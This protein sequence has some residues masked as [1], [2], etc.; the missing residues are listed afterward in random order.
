MCVKESQKYVQVLHSWPEDKRDMP[1]MNVDDVP[2]SC[3]PGKTSGCCLLAVHKQR[4]GSPAQLARG[5]VGVLERRE[6]GSILEV[7]RVPGLWRDN[8]SCPLSVLTVMVGLGEWMVGGEGG[9]GVGNHSPESC[10]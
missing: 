10:T 7:F 8:L 1:L 9:G 6:P 3:G 5:D 2:H 4:A